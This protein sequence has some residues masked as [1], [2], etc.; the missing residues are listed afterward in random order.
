MIPRQRYVSFYGYQKTFELKDGQGA[1][2]GKSIN[3]YQ[4]YRR[5]DISNLSNTKGYFVS[6]KQRFIIPNLN[7][8]SVGSSSTDSYT[9]YPA[10]LENKTSLAINNSG[11][12]R[13]SHIFPRTLNSSVTISSSSTSE[14]ASSVTHQDTSG[15]S[16]S[17]VNTFDVNANVGF[18][19]D[20]PT[21]DLGLSYS[22]SWVRGTSNEASSGGVDTASS[23]T[24]FSNAMSVKDWSAYSQ[25]SND[26]LSLSWVWGQR[27]PWDVILYNHATTGDDVSLPDFVKDRLIS[28]K[29]I[30]P[31]SEL[32]LF[33]LDFTAQAAWV[34][35]F[36]DGI[37]DSETLEISHETT[38]YSASHS[39]TDGN[40][41][42]TLQSSRE[43]SSAKYTTDTLDL[44][45][46]SL[47]P[48]ADYSAENN[49]TI[50]FRVDEFVYSPSKS[51]DKFKI[52]S[53]THDLQVTGTGF[54]SV[55]VSTFKSDTSIEIYFKI[56]NVYIDYTLMMLHWLEGQNDAQI[57]WTINDV[58]TGV[59]RLDR[60]S[61]GEN[62]A[63]STLISIR[64]RDYE[65][66]NFHDYLKIGLNKIEIKIVPVGDGDT[67]TSA[68][69]TLSSVT[70]R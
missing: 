27:Y 9:N 30:L 22:H 56:T 15:S 45:T 57:Q 68:T 41:A 38:T 59:K 7:S 5:T 40:V 32:S 34:I 58:H 1:L 63:T 47:A 70:I 61:S 37:E 13:I 4:I 60:V 64:N 12:A 10:I 51:T 54:D 36:P 43:A 39:V 28:D 24:A 31:P 62:Q 2:F 35:E 6:A 55:M 46:Y 8:Y 69:Y 19:G 17:N 29:L 42:A 52:L 25:L 65:S 44:S 14:T 23:N 20:S 67:K 11:V 66:L 16:T 49:A 53:P 33:G 48:I 50:G 3:E 21:G 18:F 26:N